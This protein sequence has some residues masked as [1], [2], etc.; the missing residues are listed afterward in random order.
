[1]PSTDA[2]N[3]G[4]HVESATKIFADYGSFIRAVISSKVKD[5]T[6]ADDIFQDFFL[7]LVHK[8][9]PKHTKNVKSYLYRAI[10]NDIVDSIRRRRR[11]E[12]LI[13]KY[14]GNYNYS[15]N[16]IGVED[17]V[18][19][20]EEVGSVL[21]VIERQLKNCE[22]QA[23]ALRYGKGMSVED[24]AN[25]MHIK[26]RSVS[27]YVSVGM[28]KIRQLLMVERGDQNDCSQP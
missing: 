6:Q 1:M 24:I 13:G 28:K 15:I 25:I 14:S 23:V 10:T 18:I 2:D 26:R 22:S 4:K 7:A 21:K 12:L 17:A 8:P 16:T 20:E 9:V 5:E 27:R 3:H 11:Y 19:T